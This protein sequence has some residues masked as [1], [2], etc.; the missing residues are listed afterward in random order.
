MVNSEKPNKNVYIHLGPP[1]TATTSLQIA[2][3]KV[4][5][6]ETLFVGTFQPRK[7]SNKTGKNN[8]AKR[9]YRFINST[10]DESEMLLLQRELEDLFEN[11]SNVIYSE[12]M[13]LHKPGWEEKVKNLYK[14]FRVYEINIAFCYRAPFQAL[15]SYYAECI[16]YLPK[17]IK[18]SAIFFKSNWC[19]MYNPE[20]VFQELKEAGFQNINIFRFSELTANSLSLNSIFGSKNKFD[21]WNIPLKIEVSNKKSYNNK[22]ILRVKKTKKYR[23]K[24]NYCNDFPWILRRILEKTRLNRSLIID[25]TLKIEIPEYLYTLEK[26]YDKFVTFHETHYAG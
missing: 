2:L 14:L 23:L 12:E 18:N 15:P 8:L 10:G 26:D 1:K 25:R 11:H 6:P 17:K 19:S 20:L 9:I 13:I 5:L 16:N 3:E 22:D 7:K 4:V 24:Y 21:T